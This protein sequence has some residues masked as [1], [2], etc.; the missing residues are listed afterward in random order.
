MTLIKKIKEEVK[1][2]EEIKREYIYSTGGRKESSAQVRLFANGK[3]NFLV[4]EKDYK[5]YFPYFESQKIINSPLEQLGLKEKFD[6]SVKVRGGG[7]RSQSESIRHALSRALVKLNP[8]YRKSLKQLKFLTRD[9]RVKERK[10]YGLKKAR[11]APQW[12]K[13]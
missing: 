11:R 1:T 13:R 12:Q 7:I 3:G 10:K 5:K 8:E 6:V 9:P 4:N 2:K